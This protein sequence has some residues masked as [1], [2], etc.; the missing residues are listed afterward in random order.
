MAKIL[1]AINA[2][3][4]T[5]TDASARVKYERDT[6]QIF[7]RAVHLQTKAKTEYMKYDYDIFSS[8]AGEEFEAYQGEA[9]QGLPEMTP[10]VVWLCVG[11]GMEAYRL[12][13][14][15]AVCVKA[16]LI[17]NNWDPMY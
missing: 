1:N 6:I 13:L 3:T 12:T 11:L 2:F 17:C 8:D 4:G 7:E 9:I 10:R 14:R 15:Q 16:S 5:S